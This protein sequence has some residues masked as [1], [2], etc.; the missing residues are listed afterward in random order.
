MLC[1]KC[2]TVFESGPEVEELAEPTLSEYLIDDLSEDNS[3]LNLENGRPWRIHHAQDIDICR[4]AED[5]CIICKA[6]WEHIDRHFLSRDEGWSQPFVLQCPQS[7]VRGAILTHAVVVWYFLIAWK[8]GRSNSI[9][10]FYL[11]PG[12][13]SWSFKFT[14]TD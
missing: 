4:S 8:G 1:N 9:N 3:P 12:R 2:L 11:I 5:G 6:L 10:E 7:N 14:L 13:F